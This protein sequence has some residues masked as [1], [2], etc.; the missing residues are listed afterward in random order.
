MQYILVTDI[1]L[2]LCFIRRFPAVFCWCVCVFRCICVVFTECIYVF[3]FIHSD[4]AGVGAGAVVRLCLDALGHHLPQSFAKV[5]ICSDHNETLQRWAL[6]SEW[7]LQSM[8]DYRWGWKYWQT[9]SQSEHSLT[10]SWQVILCNHTH[11]VIFNHLFNKIHPISQRDT[12]SP[13]RPVWTQR[14]C[15]SGFG[16]LCVLKGK[17]YFPTVDQRNH[18]HL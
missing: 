12:D 5:K 18:R 8:T 2:C 10:S 13:L 7:W 14:H 6:S 9:H 16:V 11:I 17:R 3:S 15:H 1:Q 4:G